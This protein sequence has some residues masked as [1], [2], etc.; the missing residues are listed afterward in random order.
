MT[1]VHHF[2]IIYFAAKGRK[3]KKCKQA[4]NEK[5]K[6]RKAPHVPWRLEALVHAAY[7]EKSRC[8]SKV[9]S[10]WKSLSGELG[11]ISFAREPTG[12]SVVQ[13][14]LEDLPSPAAMSPV[15]FS[16]STAGEGG[17]WGERRYYCDVMINS[18]TWDGRT[19]ACA[20]FHFFLPIPPVVLAMCVCELVRSHVEE[21]TRGKWWLR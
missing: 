17:G 19:R 5:Q 4:K 14:L 15:L 10:S 12:R 20:F 8:L 21:R 7:F 16:L 18:T 6:Q 13:G 1:R 2:P 3:R 9:D 11:L